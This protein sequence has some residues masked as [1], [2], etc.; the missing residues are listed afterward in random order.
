MTT[1][2]HAESMLALAT[3]TGRRCGSADEDT[4]R[5]RGN[6]FKSTISV[7]HRV[8]ERVVEEHLPSLRREPQ[9]TLREYM[10]RL[11]QRWPGLSGLLVEEF[12][13]HFERATY[14]DDEFTEEEYK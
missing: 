11:K 2:S 13:K 3:I 12:L 8:I 5:L 6:H 14:S 4:N 1:V 7:Q 10:A 9:E